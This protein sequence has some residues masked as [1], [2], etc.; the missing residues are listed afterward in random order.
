MD[1]T[2]GFTCNELI[3]Q[4]IATKGRTASDL[5]S[6]TTLRDQLLQGLSIIQMDY[7]GRN[8]W[9]FLHSKGTIPCISGT[10]EYTISGL[11]KMEILYDKT[12]RRI[13]HPATNKTMTRDDPS[14]TRTGTPEIYS[15]WGDQTII[16]QPTP[17]TSYT[18]Y[19]RAK[20]LP[21]HLTSV[22]D[23][24]TVPYKYQGTILHGL[25]AWFY[26]IV[27]DQR[28][29]RERQLFEQGIMQ[30]WEKD[31]LDLDDCTT[32]MSMEEWSSDPTT[33]TYEDFLTRYFG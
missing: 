33:S 32:F 10:K 23:Y 25:K 15:R 18:I 31:T 7:S 1:A 27:D 22:S 12:N 4:A 11:D 17:D 9:N 3:L 19:Y 20:I 28:A 6:D 21:T 30:D 8:D 14:E 26:D 2:S 24:L 13:I 16:L 29:D 5:I